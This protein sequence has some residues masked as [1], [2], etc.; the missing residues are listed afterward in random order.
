MYIDVGIPHMQSSA[1]TA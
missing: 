1:S